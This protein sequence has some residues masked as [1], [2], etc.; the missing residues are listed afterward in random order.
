MRQLC[1]DHYHLFNCD[2]AGLLAIKRITADAH[3]ELKGLLV[4][5][6]LVE[7]GDSPGEPEGAEGEWWE[8]W[9][10]GDNGGAL[11]YQNQ[12][13]SEGASISHASLHV[14]YKSCRPARS[15]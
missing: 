8:A 10:V 12:Q 14:L 6:G 2:T 1:Q 3:T 13:I 5:K 7:A 9:G 4:A 15:I 11:K